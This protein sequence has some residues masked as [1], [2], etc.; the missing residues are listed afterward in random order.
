ML[1][2]G[3]SA[4][5]YSACP[6]SLRAPNDAGLRALGF[7][8]SYYNDYPT[9]QGPEL[10]YGTSGTTDDFAY[11]DLGI[12]AYTFEIGPDFGSCGGFLPLY[13]CQQGLFDEN[14]NALLYAAKA[15]RAPYQTSLGPTALSIAA[16]T[17]STAAG[18]VISVTASFSDDAL[19]NGVSRPAA[20]V[21][22]SAE[23]YLDLP[24]WA[25]GTPTAMQPA[26][27]SAD[28]SAE[29]YTG[30][31][32]VAGWPTGR[33][34]VYARAQDAAGNWGPP[35]ALFVDLAAPDA[36]A[37]GPICNQWSSHPAS[38]PRTP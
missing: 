36:G 32:A 6:P 18:A 12:P 26:D 15:A 5:N 34:M 19:G 7:R 21:V 10:L 35:S 2:W 14:L 3:A 38:S 23:L 37:P 1:P 4:C 27:G 16:L 11:G 24:P 30:T 13:S 22:T 9:G 28:A 33:R 8:M 25:G 17:G 29:A 20:Q 31:L